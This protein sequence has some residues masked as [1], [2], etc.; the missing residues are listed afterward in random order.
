MPKATILSKY[1]MQS[2]F[3]Q[4]HRFENFFVERGVFL[5]YHLLDFQDWFILNEI[6]KAGLSPTRSAGKG[7]KG[8]L[9]PL[10]CSPEPLSNSPNS[11]VKIVGGDKAHMADDLGN[12]NDCEYRFLQSCYFDC[13]FPL[14]MLH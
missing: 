5:E 8:L 14:S 10:Q 13:I 1:A 9:P 3:G 4:F 7:G 11:G 2:F 6:F 12:H